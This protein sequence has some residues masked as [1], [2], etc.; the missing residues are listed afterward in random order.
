MV[1]IIIQSL[2]IRL[3]NANGST[4]TMQNESDRIR[5]VIRFSVVPRSRRIVLRAA[6]R[7]NRSQLTVQDMKNRCETNLPTTTGSLGSVFNYT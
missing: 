5:T 6:F 2:R 4:K 7:Q 3:N 1:N